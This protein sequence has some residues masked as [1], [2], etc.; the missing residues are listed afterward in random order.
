MESHNDSFIGNLVNKLH[1]KGYLKDLKYMIRMGMIFFFKQ[2]FN[3]GGFS[4]AS[5]TRVKCE[6][7]NT[8]LVVFN[9]N[10]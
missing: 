9:Y 6:Q 5:D 7:A 3:L 1:D 10:N 8:C 4:N 2:V